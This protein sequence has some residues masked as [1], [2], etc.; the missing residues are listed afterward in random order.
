MIMTMI[1][2]ECAGAD[3]I[4]LVQDR[5]DLRAFVISV[6]NNEGFVD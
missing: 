6:I 2:I 4:Q 3:W 5:I 1:K